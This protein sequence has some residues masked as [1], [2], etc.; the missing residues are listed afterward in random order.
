[1]LYILIL[2][3]IILLLFAINYTRKILIRIIPE[4]FT[5]LGGYLWL[6]ADVKSDSKEIFVKEITFEEANDTLIF[7]GVLFLLVGLL[8]NVVEKKSNVPYEEL[9]KD[10]ESQILKLENLNDEFYK[11]CSDNLRF[12][13]KDFVH[14]SEGGGRVSIY[15]YTDEKFMLIGRYAENPNYNKRKRLEYPSNEGFIA[16]GWEDREFEIYDIPKYTGNG[17]AWRDYIKNHCTIPDTTLRKI[18]MKSSS[19]YI[20]RLDNEDS[21]HQL[22]IVVFEQM[23]PKQI[24]KET[25]KYILKS[26]EQQIATLF[27]AMK[28]LY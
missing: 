17:K 2:L 14:N 8:Y 4:V 18:T 6:L 1:M 11:L 19:F 7:L 9:K 28:T 16:K 23:N 21:R 5:F 20:Y 25:I 13:F 12:I 26:Q 3:I 24:D 10:R 15:K 22:G 27:K